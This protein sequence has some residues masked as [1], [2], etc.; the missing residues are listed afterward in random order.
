MLS[1]MSYIVIDSYNSV[2]CCP[3]CIHGTS[4]QSIAS[5]AQRVFPDVVHANGTDTECSVQRCKVY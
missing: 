2:L 3:R 1:F 5:M 4:F